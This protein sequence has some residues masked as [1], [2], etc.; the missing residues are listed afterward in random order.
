M[1]DLELIQ[2]QILSAF[3]VSLHFWESTMAK[4]MKI[5]AQCQLNAIIAH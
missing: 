2:V 4:R 3:C 1:D 5:D